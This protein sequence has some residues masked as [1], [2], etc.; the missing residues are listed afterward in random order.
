MEKGNLINAIYFLFKALHNKTEL[1]KKKGCQ[2]ETVLE[3]SVWISPPSTPNDA[4]STVTQPSSTGQLMAAVTIS[5]LL[6]KVTIM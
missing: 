2:T 4:T 6:P 5:A 1:Q 3:I